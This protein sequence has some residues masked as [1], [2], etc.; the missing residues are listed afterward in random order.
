MLNIQLAQK[1][2]IKMKKYL[3]IPAAILFLTVQSSFA[4]NKLEILKGF[5]SLKVSQK[6]I[7]EANAAF[8][9]IQNAPIS[10]N[11][12]KKKANNCE[13]RAEFGYFVLN[14]LGF[15]PINFWIFKEGLIE[16]NKDIG[17]LE[18]DTKTTECK[19][20]YWKYHVATGIIISTDKG[21]DTLIYDPWTQGKLTTLREWSLSFYKPNAI[22]TVFAF[23]VIDNYF[24]FPITRKGKLMTTRESWQ[25]NL[26]TDANQMYCGLCGITPNKKCEK[27]RFKG[28]ISTKREEIIKYLKDNGIN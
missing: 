26:D 9:I 8:K 19:T 11:T 15:K 4:Q 24:Y 12:C 17:G 13:N 28:E 16:G 6:T 22:R 14:K 2:K 18:W 25:I 1:T 3:F 23:P 5:D 10:L 20:L 7:Q 27:N 21:L